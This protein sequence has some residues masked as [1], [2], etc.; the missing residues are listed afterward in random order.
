MCLKAQGQLLEAE[1]HC[2]LV[3]E[4]RKVVIGETHANTLWSMHQLASIYAGQGRLGEA[5][6]L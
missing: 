5:I 4:G 1:V 2:K 6:D 3:L